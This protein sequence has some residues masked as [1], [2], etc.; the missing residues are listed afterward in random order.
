MELIKFVINITINQIFFKI[1][2]LLQ[3]INETSTICFY[4]DQ[5][6]FNN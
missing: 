6:L 5:P 2:I 1:T 4:K 3:N